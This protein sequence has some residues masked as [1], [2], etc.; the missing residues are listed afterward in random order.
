MKTLRLLFLL[1]ILVLSCLKAETPSYQFVGSHFLVSYYDCDPKVLDDR[2]FLIKSM[3]LAVEKSGATLLQMS[4]Y[5]FAPHGVTL[6]ALLSESHASIHTYP[7]FGAC[8]VDFFT[9]GTKCD[10][11][12]F[13]KVLKA[14][15]GSKD[16]TA[17]F[18]ER[19]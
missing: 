18:I 15:L 3:T 17:Q 12:E 1:P 2:E 5:Q 7:E 16:S 11:K 8:F 14:A 10:Y 4:D 9:C 13:D 19:R 6:V